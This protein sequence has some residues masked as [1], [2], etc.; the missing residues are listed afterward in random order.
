MEEA[1][2]WIS[3]PT[4]GPR[5]LDLS[6]IVIP[7][8]SQ[9]INLAPLGAGLERE[10]LWGFLQRLARAHAVRFLD[11]LV[12]AKAPLVGSSPRGPS[13]GRWKHEVAAINGGTTGYQIARLF[14][15]LTDRDDLVSLTLHGISG[16]PGLSVVARATHACCPRCLAEDSEPYDRLLWT[17]ADVSHCPRHRRPLL[18]RC[19]EC[20]RPPRLFSTRSSVTQCDHCGR[21]KLD[22]SE[23]PDV[24]NDSSEFEL[25]QSAQ[26]ADLLDGI[27]K[28]ELAFRKAEP[29][30]HNLK[31]SALLPEVRGVTGLARE[32]G[33]GRSTPWG[34]LNQGRTIPLKSAARW[35]W[36]TGTCLRQ[37]FFD[38]LLPDNLKFRPLPPSIVSRRS[39][40]HR[41]AVSRDSTT[42]YLTALR[43]ASENPFLAPKVPAL[44]KASG[45]HLKHPAFKDVHF[46]RLMTLL[47][48]KERRFLRKERVWREVSDVHAAAVK[49]SGQHQRMSRRRVASA[50]TNPGSFGGP[51]ARS[52]LRWFSA[53]LAACDT[54]VLQP[55]QVPLDVRAYWDLQR[56]RSGA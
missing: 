53:R 12:N 15:E 8:R 51:I 34:W 50:M 31:L 47:R 22:A 38:R 36:V 40:P 33:L 1:N 11:L 27:T 25:W 24:S 48:N 35:A 6:P 5:E 17:I 41:P 30:T 13:L 29:R 23:T 10:S 45:V 14:E 54:G 44:E 21:S 28:G 3:S 55:K 32:L 18:T 2:I 46:V 19:T 39:R 20:G 16:V 26:I 43:M 4:T 37:L 42:L 56:E 49:I 9:L 7:K 52:Y